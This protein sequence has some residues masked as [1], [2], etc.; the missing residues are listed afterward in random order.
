[1]ACILSPVFKEQ[2][3]GLSWHGD[4]QTRSRTGSLQNLRRRSQFLAHRSWAVDEGEGGKG[5]G[6]AAGREDDGQSHC[7]GLQKSFLG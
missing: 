3:A 6:F 1:M 5:Q 7:C 4:L 2:S